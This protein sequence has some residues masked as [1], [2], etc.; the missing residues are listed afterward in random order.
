[1]KITNYIPVILCSIALCGCSDA[2]KTVGFGTD[3]DAIEAPATGGTHTVRVSAEKEWVATTDEPWITVSPANGRGTTECRVLID[4]ALTDQPR[5][6]VIRIM[7]QN[8]W[9]K[10]EIA[11]SQKGFDYLIG[12]DDKEVTVANYAAYGMRHFDVKIK[13]NVDFYVKVPESAENWLKFEK[14]AVEFDRGIRPREVTVR[15]NWNINSQPN[16]RI[17]D[18]TFTSK[19]EV[20]LA[21]HDNLVVTQQAAEPI[22]ENTRGGDS[23]ALLAIARTLETIA[24]WENGERMDNW[25]NVI[26]WEEGM[27]GYTPEKKGRVKYARFFMFNTKEELP[28]EV[29]YLT[30]ADEL[31]F[32]S[33]VNAFLKDLTTGEYI[34]KLTQLRRL[35]ISAYG[36][37][38]LDKNF[39][40]LKNL[41]Y[42]DLSSNNFQKVPEEINPTN[43][44]KLRTLNMGANTRKN[45]YDLSNTIETNYGT[46]MGSF[47]VAD[48]LS[49]LA[50]DYPR[51]A[52]FFQKELNEFLLMTKAEKRDVYSFKGSYAG[53]MG[54]PQ[55]M[56]SSF[57]K[58]AVDYDGDG[59]HDIWNNVGDVAASVANY[60]KAHGWQT[61]GKMVVPVTLTIN[62]ELQGIIDEKTALTRTV[63][64]FKRL[65]VQPQE[66]VADDE[67]AI[68]YRLE[69][70]PGVYEYYLGLTNFY[71]VWQYNHSRMYVTAVR[72]IANGVSGD[73][74]L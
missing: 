72:D 54:M 7:E 57:R 25:D 70:S 9:V 19:K 58:Y 62:Q 39:T 36:L 20:E 59:F 51:R 4:S 8:T 61:N 14:P 53:A 27:E 74:R 52:E 1:M 71:A 22:E 46:N 68:L 10:K 26:L 38:S 6:G 32:Y 21:R 29:Q 18:V 33:N 45:I 35:T 43:F 50:F 60:M 69:T 66:V 37:V 40:A 28:F 11:V 31:S 55:F 5:R 65:G 13:T 12:I 17:A 56:P 34:T 73:Y 3:S 30:A 23:I 49:T 41:E 48:S 42:L 15:F 63:A 44:P 24:S 16:P 2:A 47:R 64:D 67:K